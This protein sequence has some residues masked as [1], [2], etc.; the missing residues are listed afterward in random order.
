MLA[1]FPFWESA[2]FY[3][4]V[5]LSFIWVMLVIWGYRRDLRDIK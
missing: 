5:I 4:G 2:V 1:D 3:V